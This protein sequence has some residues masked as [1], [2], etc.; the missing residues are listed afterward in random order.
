MSD[1]NG[2]FAKA[3]APN[4]PATNAPTNALPSHG[5]RNLLLAGAGALACGVGAFGG[6]WWLHGRSAHAGGDASKLL[7]ASFEALD[8]SQT[9]LSQWRGKT[10]IVNFWATWCAPCREEMPDFVKAQTEYAGKGLQFVGVAIDRK[11]PVEKFVKELAINYPIVIG[12][13][14]WL[15]AL[16]TMGNPQGVL[17]FTIV[18][19]PS[20]DVMLRRVGKLKYSEITSIIA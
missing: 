15:D 4:Q 6:Y 11:Q 17:P 14:A 3:D 2:S 8:G 19:S 18:F 20:S 9:P 12:D 10:L 7:T 1:S 13:V 16:K 5:K